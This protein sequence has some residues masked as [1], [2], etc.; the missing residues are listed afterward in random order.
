M[1]YTIL[2]SSLLTGLASTAALPSL[3]DDIAARDA[4]KFTTCKNINRGEPCIEWTIITQDQ[5]SM[6]TQQKSFEL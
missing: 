5:C 3:A 4:I 2:L 6:S 1:I